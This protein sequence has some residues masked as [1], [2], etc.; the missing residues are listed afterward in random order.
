M[1]PDST[2]RRRR[3]GRRKRVHT[4]TVSPDLPSTSDSYE[5][6]ADLDDLLGGLDAAGPGPCSDRKEGGKREEKMR[7]R[8]KEE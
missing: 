4:F 5:N 1:E 6:L 8:G 3:G 2:R 7:A